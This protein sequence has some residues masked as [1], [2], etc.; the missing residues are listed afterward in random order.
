MFNKKDA[1]TSHVSEPK[2]EPVIETEA[3]DEDRPTDPSL[4][5]RSVSY[6]GPGLT[7]TG[8]INADEGLVIEGEVEGKITSA[9]KNLT[10]GKKGRV[11]GDIVGSVI[12]L[13]GTVE[14]EIF[15]DVLVRLY[16][17]AVVEGKIYCKRLVLDEGAEFNGSVDMNWDGKMPEEAPETDSDSDDSVV[18]V[19]S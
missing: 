14:G 3:N 10:V 15:S 8:E 12:E 17:S 13:R 2:S 18:R 4:S 9:D 19:V 6:I 11:T 1:D 5:A 16:S 7:L